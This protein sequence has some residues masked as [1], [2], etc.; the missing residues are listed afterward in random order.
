MSYKKYRLA[1]PIEGN[2]VTTSNHLTFPVVFV[3]QPRSSISNDI[4]LRSR[5]INEHSRKVVKKDSSKI[6]ARWWLVLPCLLLIMLCS[7]SD[8]LLMN[9]LIV[10]RYERYHGLRT[11]AD[12][13][14]TGCSQSTRRDVSLMPIFYW[15]YPYFYQNFPK[16]Q[17]DSNLVQ[18]DAANFNIKNSIATLVSSIVTFVLLGS[19]SDIIGR[20]PLLLFPFIGKVI[21][22]TLMLIIVSRDLSNTWIIITYVL[23][24]I[25]G[26]AGLVVLSTFAYITDCTNQSRTRSFFVAEVVIVIGRIIPVLAVS[27]WLR[28][29]LY[30]V[31]LTVD[32]ILSLIGLLYVLF[33]QPESVEN[34]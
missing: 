21:R 1:A 10:R 31:P 5:S 33:I 17:P 29:Y 28:Y 26:S 14:R 23:E 7:A 22:Y 13:Q 6:S 11:S 30:T 25:F 34:V 19:N 18:R 32:L 24:A 20:R 8:P 2:D 4:K 3:Y 12:T 27:L 15:E 16:Q 9:D